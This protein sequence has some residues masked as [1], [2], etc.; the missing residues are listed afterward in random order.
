MENSAS[1][2]KCSKVLYL[3]K[4]SS[5]AMANHSLLSFSFSQQELSACRSI[6]FLK[7]MPGYK[8]METHVEA[9]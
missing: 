3:S 6:L 5:P 7:I 1:K 4:N 9:E 8:V 2:L